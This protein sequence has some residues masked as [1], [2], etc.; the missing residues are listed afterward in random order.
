MPDYL[1][2]YS[3]RE[4]FL[5]LGDESK[6]IVEVVYLQFRGKVYSLYI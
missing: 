3:T 1:I 5:T 6:N 4:K 2:F